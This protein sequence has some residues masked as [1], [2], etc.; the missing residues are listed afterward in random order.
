MIPRVEEIAFFILLL[1]VFLRV[2]RAKVF[3][4][5]SFYRMITS[6]EA[7]GTILR[8]PFPL[9]KEWFSF[10]ILRL[11]DRMDVSPVLAFVAIVRLCEM[12]WSTLGDHWWSPYEYDEDALIVWRETEPLKRIQ[13]DGTEK[14]HDGGE[15]ILTIY[16]KKYESR[17][18]MMTL[19]KA[20]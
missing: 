16:R 11:R 9:I 1:G 3:G 15:D 6:C 18:M 17:E 10:S 8:L 4:R 7:R 20:A 19:A 2:A 12:N 5:L 14:W 13:A